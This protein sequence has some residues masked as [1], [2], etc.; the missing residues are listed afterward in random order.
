VRDQ[1]I[2]VSRTAFIAAITVGATGVV[3]SLVLLQRIG[4][5]VSTSYGKILLWKIG[6]WIVL[7][8]FGWYHRYRAL[9]ALSRNEAP[10]MSATLRY[11][12]TVMTAVIIVAAF[13][14]YAPLPQ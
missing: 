6:G 5:L 9:P 11:E 1:A 13:L 7:L 4:D 2:R 12:M 8:C 14:S 3:Q 10:D